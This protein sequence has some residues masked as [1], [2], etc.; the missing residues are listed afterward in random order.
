MPF[1]IS[2]TFFRYFTHKVSIFHTQNA[3]K[4]RHFYVIY[5]IFKKLAKT[6]NTYIT[7]Y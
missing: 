3:T 1:D 7:L 5:Q 6:A 4:H 2:H